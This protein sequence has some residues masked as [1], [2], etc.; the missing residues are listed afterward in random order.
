MKD[1][2][3]GFGLAA[4]LLLSGILARLQARGINSPNDTRLLLDR[5]ILT[6]ENMPFQDEA[7]RKAR[8]ALESLFVLPGVGKGKR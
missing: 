3:E 1:R 8:V 4:F 5:A 6:L 2:D 7:V